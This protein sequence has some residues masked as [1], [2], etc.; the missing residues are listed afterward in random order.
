MIYK[1]RRSATVRA[2]NYCSLAKLSYGGYEEI[3]SKYPS[4]VGRIKD[5]IQNYDD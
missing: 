2:N 5:K 4:I 3:V 1:C